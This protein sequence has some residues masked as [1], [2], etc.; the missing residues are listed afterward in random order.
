MSQPCACEGFG[1]GRHG[2]VCGEQTERALFVDID[3]AP[4]PICDECWVLCWCA[5]ISELFSYAQES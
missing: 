3:I 5:G 2:D 1:Q 4:L